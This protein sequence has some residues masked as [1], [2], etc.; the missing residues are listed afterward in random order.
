MAD[1]HMTQHEDPTSDAS[2]RA[3][4]Y[5]SVAIAAATTYANRATERANGHAD[6][7][8][9]GDGQDG[10]RASGPDKSRAADPRDGLEQA[11]ELFAPMLA[12]GA[13][14]LA[15]TDVALVAWEAAQPYRDVDR[16]AGRAAG[17]A[18]TRL[19]DL[20]PDAMARYD[21]LRA[22]LDPVEAMREVVPL[23]RAELSNDTARTAY[24]IM[25]NPETAATATSTQALAAWEAAQPLRAVLP[26]ADAAASRA[27]ARLR[28]LHPEPMARYDTLRTEHGP[29]QALAAIAPLVDPNRPAVP[30]EAAPVLAPTAATAGADA[31]ALTPVTTTDSAKESSTSTADAAAAPA[32]H[33][34]VVRAVL[35]PELAAA[36]VADK[37]WP[38]LAQA[39]DRAQAAGTDPGVVLAAVA[40]ERELGTAN[41]PA[42]VLN[43]R[44]NLGEPTAA[45]LVASSFPIDLTDTVAPRRR[46]DTATAVLLETT[47][48]ERE[49]AGM[50][51]VDAP[52]TVPTSSAT[53]GGDTTQR[54]PGP[55]APA[56][57]LAAVAAGLALAEVAG[58]EEH[59][60]RAAAATPD[61][62]TTVRVDEH[63]TGQRTGADLH[64]RAAGDADT[65]STL[66]AAGATGGNGTTS[67]ST[68]PAPSVAA[69][70]F[71]TPVGQ[72]TTEQAAT[73]VTA[74]APARPAATVT[75]PAARHR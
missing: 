23:I 19:R 41:S 54:P 55:T 36:V 33:E 7:P 43:H 42:A 22:G 38:D 17:R 63:A 8:T 53:A 72:V 71:P 67:G 26:D 57:D 18:E 34:D 75:P 3:A 44:L 69:A 40:A 28:D 12:R 47:P 14:R 64:V 4:S 65:A 35:P 59:R 30:V 50:T 2:S 27:E 70:N 29:D 74:A 68:G 62:V 51:P 48:L 9:T 13:G 24:A 5:I 10:P 49:P 16:D 56:V 45:D 60:S 39:L 58:A 61:D 1:E 15:G 73:A 25:A 32:R 31:P 66:L 6:A 11:R 20:Q 52:T 46:T 21:A 37:A